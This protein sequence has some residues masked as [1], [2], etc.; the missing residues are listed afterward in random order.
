MLLLMLCLFHIFDDCADV[1]EDIAVDVDDDEDDNN[2]LVSMSSGQMN[3]G[4]WSY[5]M[6]MLM[7]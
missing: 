2:L 7:L 1:V 3:G 6:T 4:V 5:L